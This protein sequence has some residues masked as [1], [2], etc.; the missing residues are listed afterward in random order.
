MF[1]YSGLNAS[2][3]SWKLYNDLSVK[4]IQNES[5]TFLILP[6][7]RSGGL[8]LEIIS[9]C[10]DIIGQQRVALRETAD[11]VARAMENGAFS[12]AEEFIVFYRERM[13]RSLT[14]IEA[15][16]LILDAAPLLVQDGKG[17]FGAA[18]GL[19]GSETDFA[20]VNQMVAEAHNPNGAFTLLQLK[21]T[22]DAMFNQLSDNR[23]RTVL[24]YEILGNTPRDD[25]AQILYDSIRRSIQHNILIRAALCVDAIK[26][27]KKGKCTK[28]TPELEKRC[29]SLL[30]HTVVSSES[31]VTLETTGCANLLQ[32]LM[33]LCVA[34]VA[35][36][37]GMN[38]N[39]EVIYDSMDLREEA[40]TSCVQN[41][42][43]SLLAARRELTEKNDWSV[44]RSS[45]LLSD[46]VSPLFSVFQMCAK[47]VDLFGWG[48]R[49]RKTKKCSA[50]V[51]CF[52]ASFVLLVCDMN[53]SVQS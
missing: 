30:K 49:K 26:G 48:R 50:A 43:E 44:S 1:V 28:S 42:L 40:T 11:F 35:L 13:V 37:A 33:H 17:T 24:S 52:A 25:A 53:S 20:R 6:L 41:A 31:D 34:M 16:G 38:V 14:T 12:K 45:R 23:D 27:P 39:G 7:L 29:I 36:G 18:H 51:S 5:C 2:S 19:V 3:R 8:Y 15:K 46:S 4:H 47:V 10:Q 9:V 21:G 32:A 22:V